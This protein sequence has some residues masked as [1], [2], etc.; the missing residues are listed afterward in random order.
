MEYSLLFIDISLAEKF[1]ARLAKT[2]KVSQQR[3]LGED[4]FTIPLWSANG[5]IDAE[6]ILNPSDNYVEPP[7][8]KTDTEIDRNWYK[9]A[10][11][12][13]CVVLD[14]NGVKLSDGYLR[15]CSALFNNGGNAEKFN[16]GLKEVAQV[17]LC[18]V[19]VYNGKSKTQTLINMN[20]IFDPAYEYTLPKDKVERAKRKESLHILKCDYLLNQVMANIGAERGW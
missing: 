19:V 20:E 13:G 18:R 4:D 1:N 12:L 5:D 7:F 3:V 15:W 11:L 2:V 8:D 6:V 14:V 17:V 16:A 10:S 9:A